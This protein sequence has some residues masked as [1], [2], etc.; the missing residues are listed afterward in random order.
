[1][2]KY[3]SSQR[4]VDLYDLGDG[5]TLMNII[6]NN[7][8]GRIR[9]IDTYIGEDRKVFSFVGHSEGLDTLGVIFNYAKYVKMIEAN[10]ESY[11]NAYNKKIK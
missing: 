4:K 1:M 11:L 7:D 10:L 3:K 2:K 6:V 5:L 8:T 9:E